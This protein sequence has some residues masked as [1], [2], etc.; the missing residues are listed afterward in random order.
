MC[1]TVWELIY[2]L[3]RHL[4][5]CSGF[6]IVHFH[7]KQQKTDLIRKILILKIRGPVENT[8]YKG[9]LRTRCCQTPGLYDEKK[10]MRD[11]CLFSSNGDI[12]LIIL[13]T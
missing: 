11:Y 7:N 12:I 4:L 1:C 10:H 13:W 2:F 6:V 8:F 9:G 5:L 3:M